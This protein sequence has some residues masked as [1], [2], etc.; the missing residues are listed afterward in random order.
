MLN[1]FLVPSALWW[2]LLIPCVIL[3]YFLKLKRQEYVFSSTLLWQKVVNDMRVNSPF[4]KLKNNLLL[5]LQI[6]L[7]LLTI[8]ALARPFLSQQALQGRNIVLIIDTSTSMKALDE[9]GKSRLSRAKQKAWEMVADLNNDDRMMIVTFNSHSKI[10]QTFTHVKTK[11]NSSIQ[12]ISAVD[13][14]TNI[15]EALDI[16]KAMVNKI[17]SPS[18][19]ILTDGRIDS[20]DKLLNEYMTNKD[21]V[22]PQ[23]IICGQSSN[24]VAITAF[25]IKKNQNTNDYQ[26][27]IQ[28]QNFGQGNVEV[29]VELNING[30]VSQDNMRLVE[31]GGGDVRGVILNKLKLPTGIIAAKINIE[32]GKD[33]LKE[34]NYAW[35]IVPPD[36]KKKICLVGSGNF[37]LQ[38]A[39][40]SHDENLWL[41][42]LDEYNEKSK[43]K[44]SQLRKYDIIVFDQASPKRILPGVGN[45]FFNCVP[46]QQDV[47][48][49]GE[50]NNKY[51][52]KVVDQNSLHPIMRFVDLRKFYLGKIMEISWPEDTTPLLE[53]EGQMVVGLITRQ[54]VYSLVVGFDIFQSGWPFDRT[55]P[56][57]IANTISWYKGIHNQP[58]IITS[59]I[60]RVQF[61]ED[62]ESVNVTH[63]DQKIFSQ[64][65]TANNIRFPQTKKMGVYRFDGYDAHKNLVETRYIAANL[66]SLDE[67]R[68]APITE[69]KLKK[70]NIASRDLLAINREIWQYLLLA[71]FFVLLIE[72]YL[73][74][75]RSFSFNFRKSNGF[76]TKHFLAK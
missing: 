76:F 12:N 2:L 41:L 34:D 30:Q 32:Q 35:F 38:K 36:L 23:I 59:D 37:I 48:S 55:F 16:A 8:F 3:L 43:K 75:R 27:F 70:Q 42:T 31:L 58:N 73:F 63:K 14:Y 24:N 4:Q 18:I 44:D 49:S 33:Y 56:I 11:L 47:K 71:A 28:L 66:F 54:N 45:I 5:F 19:F 52:F 9:E 22:I 50:L 26:A 21:P 13:T 20:L 61:F 72:W 53:V 65:I 15:S 74:H 51:G 6:L 46:P 57:F 39:L 29:V 40:H 7:L 1:N 64:K 25:D 62:T 68:I 60:A 67:S 10:V 69:L 17:S